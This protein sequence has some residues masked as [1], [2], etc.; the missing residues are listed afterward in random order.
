MGDGAEF[1]VFEGAPSPCLRSGVKGVDDSRGFRGKPKGDV[2]EG[3]G[4]L[5]EMLRDGTDGVVSD[6]TDGFP[7]DVGG[8]IGA[9][10][11]EVGCAVGPS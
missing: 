7:G 2:E 1:I 10:V 4:G 8:D 3:A 11:G 6:R 9:R 5:D